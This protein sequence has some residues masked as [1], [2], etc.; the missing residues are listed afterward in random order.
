MID[1][2][3]QSTAARGDSTRIALLTAAIEIF[4]RDGF[5]AAATRAIAEAAGVNQALIGYH[6]GG[7]PGLYLAAVEHIGDCVWQRIGPL[8]VSV[9]SELAADAPTMSPERALERLGT[10]TDGLVAM[11]TS[12]ESAAWARVMLREQQEPTEGFDVLYARVMSRALGVTTRL[13]VQARKLEAVSQEVKLA[14]LSIL[15]QALVFRAARAAVMR[16]M[17]WQQ[18][19]RD[20]VRRIQA[21]LRRN[22]RAIVI[23][24]S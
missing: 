18:I 15:G 17:G 6:F 7:K 2:P 14:A 4:G 21:E 11:L 16:H 10:L 8:V 19:G 22:V 20:Q 23:Q 13:I 12:P 24:E 3:S 5:A 9:E 1:A